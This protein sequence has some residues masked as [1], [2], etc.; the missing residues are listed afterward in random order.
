M[1]RT[2]WLGALLAAAACAS[3]T[4]VDRGSE[5]DVSEAL[6]RAAA[7]RDSLYLE[8]AKGSLFQAYLSAVLE[9]NLTRGTNAVIA[10]AIGAEP[11]DA[12]DPAK[13]PARPPSRAA[14]GSVLP[15]RR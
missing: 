8:E 3:A 12:L 7:Q 6:I 11:R 10:L 1:S 15:R 14:R 5:L 2:V 9:C 13:A 4:G